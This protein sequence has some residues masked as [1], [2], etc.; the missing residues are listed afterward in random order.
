VDW[1]AVHVLAVD[2]DP[3]VREYFSEIAVRLGFSCET[4]SGGEEALELINKKGAYD[5]YFVDWKMPGLNGIELSRKIKETGDPR[6]LVVMISAVEWNTVE[7]E[8][9]QAGVDGFLSKPLFP[10]G[11]ADC[12]SRSLGTVEQISTVESGGEAIENFEGRKIILAEDV[13]IN[14]EIVLT[15]LEPTG[16][17]IDCAENGAEAVKL[18]KN[19]PGSYSMIFM[20][21]QMPEMDGYEATRLI[22]AFEAEQ[23]EK[24]AK[25]IP[26]IAMTANVFKED[27]EQCLEAGM[28]GHIG[29]PLDF[30]E[31]MGK[32]R[33]Y[34]A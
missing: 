13:D 19:S 26:I 5:M 2:D 28:D 33:H 3:D 21:V 32:L 4:A 22:R 14:R 27:I 23:P 9:K 31:V 16:V 1:S 34:L 7:G 24:D 18:F 29:K 20:D 25:R 10:S 11:I 17:T 8:A 6:S 12:I 15:L 30:N